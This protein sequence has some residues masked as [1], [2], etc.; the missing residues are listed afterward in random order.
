[1]NV[2]GLIKQSCTHILELTST[3]NVFVM[4][5]VKHIYH[6][7]PVT[8]ISCTSLKGGRDVKLS[9]QRIA[10]LHILIY[11]ILVACVSLV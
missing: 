8:C 5:T 3:M 2:Q 4:D 7:S 1:M 6:H 11:H 10:Q 9:Q